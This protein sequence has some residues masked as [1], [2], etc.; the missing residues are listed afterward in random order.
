MPIKNRKTN[1]KQSTQSYLPIAQIRDNVVVLKDG[2]I[3]GVLKVSSL[4]LELKSEDEQIATL[5]AYQQ[6]LNT[7][8]FPI[9][10]VVQSRKVDL[11]NYFEMFRNTTKNI[12]NPLLKEQA[13]NYEEFLKKITEYADIMEKQFLVVVPADPLRVEGK[14]SIIFQ[15]FENIAPQDS[16]EKIKTRYLE[17]QSLSEVLSKRMDIV[18][19]GLERC[20]LRVKP[21]K[22]NDLITLYYNCYNPFVA[23]LEKLQDIEKY[24]VY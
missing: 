20:G 8:D 9:Q 19:A 7:I 17:F 16:L 13:K 15:F 21:L 18:S 6:F 23:K 22:D 3:R 4:N 2:G 11:D 1:F 5:E 14:K 24:A 10:I 12:E